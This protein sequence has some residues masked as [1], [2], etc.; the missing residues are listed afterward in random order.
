MLKQLTQ[1]GSPAPETVLLLIKKIKIVEIVCEIFN[2]NPLKYF[3]YV[4]D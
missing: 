2:N 1:A 4:G 3:A